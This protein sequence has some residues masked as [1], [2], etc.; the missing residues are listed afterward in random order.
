VVA[1]ETVVEVV[2]AEPVVKLVAPVAV[3]EAVSPETVVELR[4]VGLGAAVLAGPF[5]LDEPWELPHAAS[6]NA[7][8]TG[9]TGPGRL[10]FP[11]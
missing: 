9:R 7:Q 2:A 8:A 10:T 6:R 5:D 3:V 11:G 4:L 1:P